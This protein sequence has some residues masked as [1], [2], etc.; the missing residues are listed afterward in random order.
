MDLMID[1]AVAPGHK[2]SVDLPLHPCPWSFLRNAHISTQGRSL[3][4]K[5][6]HQLTLGTEGLTK[7][8]RFLLEC[9]FEELTM[10]SGEQQEHWLVAIQAVWEASCIQAEAT[11]TQQQCSTDTARRRALAIFFLCDDNT[12]Y[13]QR[14]SGDLKKSQ[15]YY[16]LEGES[17]LSMV[18]TATLFCI[19]RLWRMKSPFWSNLSR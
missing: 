3:H 16:I 18:L 12:A 15:R 13:A 8:N 17:P 11:A 14:H 4:K 19:P 1:Q 9:N 7:E 5:I 2:H 6:K 10:T